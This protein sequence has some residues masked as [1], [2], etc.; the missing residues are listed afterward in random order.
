MSDSQEELRAALSAV[1]PE[2]RPPPLIAEFAIFLARRGHARHISVTVAETEVAI[3][4]ACAFFAER[5]A[6]LE[7]TTEAT[8]QAPLDPHTKDGPPIAPQSVQEA[9]TGQSREGSNP[10]LECPPGEFRLCGVCRYP[11]RVNR[12]HATRHTYCSAACRSK[13][14]HRRN[15][16]SAGSATVGP[17]LPPGHMYLELADPT[18]A[19]RLLDDRL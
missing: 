3:K 6:A 13:A 4:A 11:F 12:R 17:L 5:E 19:P 10:A 8:L 16:A 2:H 18:D 7:E 1:I 9:R 14:R 15:R